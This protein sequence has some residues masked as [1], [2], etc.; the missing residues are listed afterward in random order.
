MLIFT[1][2][3]KALE[4]LATIK[5]LSFYYI[6]QVTEVNGNFLTHDLV[7]L[8]YESSVRGHIFH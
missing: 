2:S 3:L 4:K 7:I 5:S 1:P 6:G 8:Y